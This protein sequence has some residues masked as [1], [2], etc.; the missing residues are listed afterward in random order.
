MPLQ[1]VEQLEPRRLLSAAAADESHVNAA[2]VRDEL[3]R[4]VDTWNGGQSGKT[5]TSGMGVY[6]GTWD[7]LFRMNMDRQF[8][9]VVNTFTDDMTIVAQSRGIYINVEAYR[10]APDP[11][12]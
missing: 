4:F 6:A 5:G 9:R 10:N 11:A 3:I 1:C 12:E 8:R 7:G 2:A